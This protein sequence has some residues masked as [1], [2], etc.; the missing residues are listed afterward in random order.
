M[1]DTLH[2]LRALTSHL[3]SLVQGLTVSLPAR[4]AGGSTDS[5]PMGEASTA[6]AKW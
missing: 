6:G 3:S 5:T 1:I 2:W 4:G